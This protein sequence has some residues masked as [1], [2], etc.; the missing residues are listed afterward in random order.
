MYDP[1][2]ACSEGEA[3]QNAKEET[4]DEDNDKWA[5]VGEVTTKEKAG[6]QEPK[7]E[8]KEEPNEEENEEEGKVPTN[9]PRTRRTAATAKTVAGPKA[10]RGRK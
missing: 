2:E 6:E 9:S 3:N 5:E 1:E 8:V 4:Q 10:K 7:V